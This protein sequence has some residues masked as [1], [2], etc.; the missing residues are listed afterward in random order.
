MYITMSPTKPTKQTSTEARD[1]MNPN[2]DRARR[3]QHNADLNLP[4]QVAA[5]VV[6]AA[7]PVVTMPVLYIYV[8][9]LI[10]ISEPTRPY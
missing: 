1:S 3:S 9:S 10:H 4:A 6:A 2:P 5:A 8:L 7:T